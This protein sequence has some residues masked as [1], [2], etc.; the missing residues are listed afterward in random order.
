MSGRQIVNIIGGVLAGI[1]L[2]NVL[3]NIESHGVTG[4]LT[5]IA[6]VLG[7]CWLWMKFR[8]DLANAIDEET[9]EDK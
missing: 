5:D 6:I 1:T 3:S 2:L 9:K 4:S 8:R 7:I